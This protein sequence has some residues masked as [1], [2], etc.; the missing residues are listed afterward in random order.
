MTPNRRQ[1]DAK[2]RHCGVLGAPKMDPGLK[3][4]LG[5]CDGLGAIIFCGD[6]ILFNHP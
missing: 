1:I 6:N 5:S 2:G 4:F 3:G